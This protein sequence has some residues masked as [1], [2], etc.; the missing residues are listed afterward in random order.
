MGLADTPLLGSLV[1]GIVFVVESRETRS[2]LAKI[3]VE[4]L[5][6]SKSRVIGGLLTKFQAQKAQYG[7]GYDYGYGYGGTRRDG[8]EAA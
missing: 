4:R 5:R 6:G 3:A 7:Y 2:S 1:E 8:T